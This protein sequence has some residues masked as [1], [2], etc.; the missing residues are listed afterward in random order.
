VRY[1]VVAMG[2][3]LGIG[4]AILYFAWREP[5]AALVSLAVVGALTVAAWF[6]GWPRWIIAAVAVTSVASTLPQVGFQLSYGVV[7]PVATA[8]QYAIEITAFVLLFHPR[9]HRWYHPP[10]GSG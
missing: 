8:V 2:V 6:S 7:V 4:V 1:G 9:S 3:S 10:R 5:R